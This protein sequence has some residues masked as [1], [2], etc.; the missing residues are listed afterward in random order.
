MSMQ[1]LLGKFEKKNVY[2][3]LSVSPDKMNYVGPF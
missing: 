2:N 1:K 3:Q